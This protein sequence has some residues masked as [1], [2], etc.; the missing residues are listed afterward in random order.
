MIR[1]LIPSDAEFLLYE[2]RLKEL[3]KKNKNK[4]CDDKSFTFIT[5][6]TFFYLFTINGTIIGAIYFF[7]DKDK[8]F[9]NAFAK[10]KMFNEKIYCLKQSLTWFNCDIYAEAQ[11]KASALC[12]IKCG[13]K[14]IKNNL[15]VYRQNV[16][17]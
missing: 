6:Q 14:R 2:S 3:Y 16:I 1:V 12:L 4:I 17:D 10:R 11:N 7:L 15:F 5:K 8:L 13:F 9:L